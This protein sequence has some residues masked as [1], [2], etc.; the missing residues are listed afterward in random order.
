MVHFHPASAFLAATI[1]VTR[2]VVAEQAHALDVVP[3]LKGKSPIEVIYLDPDTHKSVHEEIDE[4]G[5]GSLQRRNCMCIP[6]YSDFKNH[7]LRRDRFRQSRRSHEAAEESQRLWLLQRLLPR[8]LAE[9]GDKDRSES[10][11]ENGADHPNNNAIAH[12]SDSYCHR[13]SACGYCCDGDCLFSKTT[14]NS[15]TA[16]AFTITSSGIVSQSPVYRIYKADF[17]TQTTVFATQT[18]VETETSTISIPTEATAPARRNIR[19]PS[20]LKG[21]ANI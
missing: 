6:T 2:G 11:Y 10:L 1:L 21:F 14:T 19:P 17:S 5:N 7:S 20:W 16:D 9:A 18:V 4:N 12:D 13:R 8:I 3:E 15:V